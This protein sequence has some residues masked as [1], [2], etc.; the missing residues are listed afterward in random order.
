MQFGVSSG[1]VMRRST[2]LDVARAAGVSKWTVMRAFKP[3]ASIAEASRQRVIAAA[4][5]L[6][7]RPNLVARSLAT[8]T[9]QQ[10]AI[11]VD[12]FGNP[13]K[14]PT[15]ELL[16]AA[17][18]AEDMVAIL[19]N[20]NQRFDQVHALLN[21]AQRQVDAV[22]LFGTSFRDE[23][24]HDRRL[25][26]DGPPIY[27]VARESTVPA[28]PSAACDCQ[29]SMEEMCRY[30]H[31]RGYRRPGYM[32][33]PKGFSDALGRHRHFMAFWAMHGI[34][35]VP[36]L[37]AGDYER[38]AGERALAAHLSDPAAPGLDL[39]MCETDIL[40]LGAIDAARHR[41][42]VPQDL[43]IAG[44]DGIEIAGSPAYDLTTYEQPVAAM[45]AALVDMITGR[46]PPGAVRL[47]G[48]LLVRGSA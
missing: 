46:R 3:G 47:P 25:I 19:I 33:G 15:L 7:Y 20:I 41:L 38:L 37:A 39:L 18:Q 36:E 24:L 12:D 34:T 4:E 48:R 45:V 2:A 5:R 9:T 43:A 16:T 14:L 42:R 35:E 27:V 11:L 44:Y 22:V 17:L 6:D 31:G 21:A 32:A 8:S 23:A 1:Q 30:L 13:Y 10:V 40:A 29:R 28:I 26:A